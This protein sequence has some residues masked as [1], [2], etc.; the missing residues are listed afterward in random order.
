VEV[1]MSGR[2]LLPERQAVWNVQRFAEDWDEKSDRVGEGFA[3]F[4]SAERGGACRPHKR[5]RERRAV[6][7]IGVLGIA[8]AALLGACKKSG[9]SSEGTPA[10]SAATAPD[11]SPLIRA[12]AEGFEPPEV[13]LGPSRRLVFRR[14]TD[15]TCATSVVFPKLGI[16]KPLPLNTDVAID[17]P[18][19]AKGDFTFQCGMA[20]YK[21]KV[22]AQ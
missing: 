19:T 11:G 20:M 4:T 7:L 3:E 1:E 13:K 5:S 14:T 10:A 2:R 16:D 8:L 12:T 22:V 15:E 18:A 21:G 6:E 17:L 9:G